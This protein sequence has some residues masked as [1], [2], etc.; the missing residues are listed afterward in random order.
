MSKIKTLLLCAAIAFLPAAAFAQGAPY[1]APNAAFMGHAQG[2]GNVPVATICG[3][4]PDDGSTDLQGSITNVGLTTCTITFAATWTKAPSCVITNNTVRASQ[5][6]TVTATAI[7]IT[8]ITAG[9]KISWIC[10]G[11]TGG[12]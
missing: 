10:F 4:Q 12:T 7:T 11:K 6:N 9:D 5:V 3:A 1:I 2:S 8:A